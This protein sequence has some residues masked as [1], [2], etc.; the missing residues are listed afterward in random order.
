M[1]SVAPEVWSAQSAEELLELA[2]TV[3]FS[4]LLEPLDP[5]ESLDPDP[6]ESLEELESELLDEE[7]EPAFDDPVRESVL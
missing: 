1:L 3:D 4:P 2:L 5:T 6:L 7:L